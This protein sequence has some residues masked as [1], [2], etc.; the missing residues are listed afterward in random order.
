MPSRHTL[1]KTERVKSRKLTEAIF[2]GGRHFTVPALRVCWLLEPSADRLEPLQCGV[3]VSSRHFKKAVDRNRI[4][5]LLREAWRLQKKPLE[6][7]LEQ[8]G[9][10]LRLFLIYT[11]REVPPY[12]A[13][14]AKVLL[15]IHRLNSTL[16]ENTPPAA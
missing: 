11:G 14:A 1:G 3:A 16:H 8:S 12:D 4:K 15:S 13:L 9:H 2:A 7:A 10:R 5:R 6:A